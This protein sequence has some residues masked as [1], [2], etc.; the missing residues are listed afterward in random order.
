M[1]NIAVLKSTYKQDNKGTR[2]E[3]AVFVR[4]FCTNTITL[5]QALE[6]FAAPIIAYATLAAANLLLTNAITAYLA[7]TP[8]TIATNLADMISKMKAVQSL[9]DQQGS[10]VRGVANTNPVNVEAVVAIIN[11]SVFALGIIT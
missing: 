6:I 11:S 7:S 10:F 9:L 4:D 1:Q 3:K 5:M 8:A 2:K